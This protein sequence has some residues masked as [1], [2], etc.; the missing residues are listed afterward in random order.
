MTFTDSVM[1]FFDTNMQLYTIESMYSTIIL[2]S[3][4]SLM[5]D[6]CIRNVVIPSIL[7]ALLY[8]LTVIINDIHSSI[9]SN[10]LSTILNQLD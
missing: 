1:T 7:Y 6:N 4:N 9:V 2:N 3:S 8:V 5:H 10:E